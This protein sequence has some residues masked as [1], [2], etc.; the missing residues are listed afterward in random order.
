MLK[1]YIHI[2]LLLCILILSFRIR[3]VAPLSLADLKPW[4]DALEYSLSAYNLYHHHIYGIKL[5]GQYYPSH[6]PYGYPLL[7]IPFYVIFGS[8]PYNAVYCSL[9]FAL[10]SIVFA[11]MIGKELGNRFTGIIA[12]LFV[13]LCPSHA[14]FS[15][16]ILTETSSVFFTLLICWLLLRVIATYSK[17]QILLLLILGL[18]TG[19]SVS[20]HLTNCLII[21]PVLISLLLV[22]KSNYW[23]VLKRE[24]III[25]G[26]ILALIPLFLYQLHTF[27]SPLK[28]GYQLWQPELYG[29]FKCFSFKF[30]IHPPPHPQNVWERGNFQ[31]YL[32]AL[33]GLE[34]N[35]Y[36]P[37]MIPLLLAG[38]LL[39]LSK[40]RK[41][42][43][44][45]EFLI[46]SSI[47]VTSL[48]VFFSFYFYQ[49]SR[50]LLPGVPLLM[51]LA[52]YGITISINKEIFKSLTKQSILSFTMLSLFLMILIQL[53][54]CNY[55]HIKSLPWIVNSEYKLMQD[56]TSHIS[57]NA[58]IISEFNPM[59]AEHYL[60]ENKKIVNITISPSSPPFSPYSLKII[61]GYLKPIKY[62]IKKKYRFLLSPKG[63]L[64]PRTYNFIRKSLKEGVPVYLVYLP[65]NPVSKRL[66]PRIKR[67]FSRIRQEG[68]KRLFRLYLKDW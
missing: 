56:I 5:F 33:A 68:D 55:L 53:T 15:K 37:Y 49:D 22:R 14:G 9:F 50:L 32:F 66:F 7:I 11:Y 47:L 24:T 18:V 16:H 60:A 6:Y 36:P 17:K 20:V 64:N 67:Y 8:Q 4:P 27:G 21:P 46:F 10:L 57:D 61:K 34:K 23:S 35:F 65:D 31:V 25:F 59:I 62:D 45:M 44:Q 28:T 41:Q 39:I 3:Y 51:I 30:L 48:F 58:I 40:R 26:I 38:S 13:A 54:Y 12:A 52:A 2:V 29:K 63:A 19:F 1:K 42:S 43:K